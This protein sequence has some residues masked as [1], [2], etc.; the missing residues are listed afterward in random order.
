MNSIKEKNN[1]LNRSSQYNWISLAPHKVI[2]FK[3]GEQE[4]GESSFNTE[5]LVHFCI[6][7]PNEKSLSA[8]DYDTISAMLGN[9]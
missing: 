1:A 6:L 5:W 9:H 2:V 3:S 7:L 4:A 8:G